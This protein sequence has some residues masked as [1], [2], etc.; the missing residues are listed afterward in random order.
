MLHR[1]TL[2]LV[3]PFLLFGCT[4]PKPGDVFPANDAGSDQGDGMPDG[5]DASDVVDG[6]TPGDETDAPAGVDGSD[7]SGDEPCESNCSSEASFRCDGASNVQVC[8]ARGTCLRWL[9]V[10]VCPSNQLCCNGACSVIDT[11]NCYACGRTCQDPAPACAASLKGCSC[12]EPSCRAHGQTCNVA[13][14][15]CVRA[16]VYVDQTAPPGG[17]GSPAAPLQTITAALDA[18]AKG[19]SADRLVL[20]GAGTYDGPHGET[21]PLVLRGVALEGIG[22]TPTRIEG[23]GVYQLGGAVSQLVPAS[24]TVTLVVGDDT[25]TT[26]V[27]N[28][29]VASPPNVKPAVF[30]MVCDRGNRATYPGPA[31]VAPNTLLDRVAVDGPSEYAI[32]VGTSTVPQ[33]SGCNL[34]MTRSSVKNAYIGIYAVGC[35]VGNSATDPIRDPVAIGIDLG[36]GTQEGGNT[37][38]QLTADNLRG[39]GLVSGD[40]LRSF[41]SRWGVFR[42]SDAGMFVW[43]P[44]RH[45]QMTSVFTLEHNTFESLTRYGAFLRGGA[46]DISLADNVFHDIGGSVYLGYPNAGL[47]LDGSLMEPP[48]FF[49]SLKARRNQFIDNDIGVYIHA[50]A[51]VTFTPQTVFGDFGTSADP[52]NNVFACNSSPWVRT[53]DDPWGLKGGDLGIQVPGVLSL[54]FA[55]NQWDHASPTYATISMGPN[56]SDILL[57]DTN[58]PAVNTLNGSAAQVTCTR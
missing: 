56:G 40:C 43:L 17:D 30:A 38:S 21:F 45:G 18:I 11:A 9:D 35:F 42:Q 3:A 4:S 14:G 25:G 53:T 7:G 54:S 2:A 22:A 19:R 58:A 13:T 51:P 24:P 8:T 23:S 57:P 46:M 33:P 15:S 49:H 50:D 10:G 48:L 41:R 27:S 32:V 55:G 26:H 28:V 20:V 31:D 39:G 47:I 44:E 5:R 36:D 6:N 34:Q 16:G 52:G 1:F 29:V 12:T 37:F